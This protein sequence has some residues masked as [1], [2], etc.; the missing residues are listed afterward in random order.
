MR[1]SNT[2]MQQLQRSIQ[3]AHELEGRILRDLSKQRGEVE[4]REG[5]LREVGGRF[6]GLIGTLSNLK[7]SLGCFTQDIR[8]ECMSI[9]S[10]MFGIFRQTAQ[11]YEL[12]LGN[13]EKDL[14]AERE[15][16][17]ELAA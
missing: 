10:D 13:S 15:K 17:S 8:N 4:R 12:R 6:K 7:E 16:S 3:Q 11:I 14:R 2:M 1:T 9:Y 5:V